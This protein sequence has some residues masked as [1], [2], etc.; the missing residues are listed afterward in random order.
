MELSN[1]KFISKEVVINEIIRSK[2]RDT[3]IIMIGVLDKQSGIVYPHPITH[4]IKS[5]Y[6]FDGRSVNSQDS[7]AQIVCR[8]LNFCLQKI[9]EG[10][11]DF[12]ELKQTGLRGLRRRHASKFITHLTLEGLQRATV[13]Y[14]ERYLSAFYVYLKEMSLIDEDF[15]L[16]PVKSAKKEVIYRSVFQDA[17]LGRRLPSKETAKKRPPKLKDFGEDRTALTACFITLAMDKAPD[18]ALGLCFQFYG[19][20]RRGEVVNLDRGSLVI[21][22]NESMEV[23]IRDNRKGFFFRLKDT[24][25]ENPKRLNYLNVEMARQTILDNDLVWTIYKKHMKQLDIRLKNGEIKNARALFVDKDGNP[26]SGKTYDKRFNKVKKDFIDLIMEHK[27]YEKISGA[28]WSTHIGRG[29]FT[30]EL[31]DMG[32]TVTQ[33]AI[34]RGD[35]NIDSALAYIDATLTT[36]QIR[37][38]VNEF[39]KH[40]IEELGLVDYKDVLNLKKKKGA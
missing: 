39:K 23:Q 10:H 3:K 14:Y 6:E 5:K 20:L 8:L 40:P 18:I 12:V 31:I 2:M 4:F 28:V 27:D 34:A 25:A 33:L 17:H 7:P 24:K 16:K 30:N 37:E 15:L 9:E 32:F 22:E 29:V 35:R 11:K 26:M 38:A 13:V 19:G 36:E 21:S 1:Y